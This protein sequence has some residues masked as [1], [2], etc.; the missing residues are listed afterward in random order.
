MWS[1]LKIIWWSLIQCVLLK[2]KLVVNW[3]VGT[4]GFANQEEVLG[5]VR[6]IQS[7]S[8]FLCVSNF[9][10]YQHQHCQEETETASAPFKLFCCR[11]HR[12]QLSTF[13][14]LTWN[15]NGATIET[16]SSLRKQVSLTVPERVKSLRH[17][18]TAHPPALPA[19][20]WC[21]KRQSAVCQ[22]ASRRYSGTRSAAICSFSQ[23]RHSLSGHSGSIQLGPVSD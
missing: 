4:R 18:E 8:R 5:E 12:E 2:N 11:R 13:F 14:Y 16:K 9:A 7:E 22:D 1:I 20:H 23:K 3:K 17:F 10:H 15:I 19:K 21:C 6:R